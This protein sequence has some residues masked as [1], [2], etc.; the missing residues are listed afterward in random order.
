DD[1]LKRNCRACDSESGDGL[2]QRGAK[3]VPIETDFSVATSCV[4]S[5]RVENGPFRIVESGDAGVRRVVVRPYGRSRG[6]QIW[7]RASCIY[8]ENLHI[9]VA[10]VTLNQL[11]AF[12]GP[13]IDRCVRATIGRSLRR[14]ALG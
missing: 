10:P 6:V 13:Q 7:P 12:L 2:R 5:C 11:H 8:L 14:P 4:E 9:A 3:A 1:N